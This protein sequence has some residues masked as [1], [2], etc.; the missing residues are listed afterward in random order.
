MTRKKYLKVNV[1]EN[2]LKRKARIY[3]NLFSKGGGGFTLL[4]TII[5]VG[6]VVVGLTTALALLGTSV[7]AVTIV[8][9]RITAA[10]LVQEGVEVTRNIRDNNWLQNLPWDQGL[11]NGD[12]QAEWDS[13]SLSPYAGNPILFDA[14]S[15][16]YGYTTGDLTPYVRKITITNVSPIEIMAEV[17]VS[18]ALRDKNYTAAAEDHFFN[19]K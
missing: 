17:T 3:S 14:A 11:S 7:S 10:N 12:Y 15:N 1:G 18:W 9:E 2:A 8:R 16:I 4:E 13:L 5:A 19:W 6:M